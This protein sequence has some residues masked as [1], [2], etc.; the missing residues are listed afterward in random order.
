MDAN[1]LKA[2]LGDEL[3]A[4]VEAKLTAVE[5]LRIIPTNDGSWVPRSR[6]DEEIGKRKPLQDT[7][8]T[9]NADLAEARQKLEASGSLQSQVDQLTR[10]L[11]DRDATITGMRRSGKIREVLSKANLRDISIAEKLLDMSQIKE[12]DKG[13]LTGI[14]EQ[15]K[16]L[17]ESSP[18]LFTD[19]KQSDKGGYFGGNKDHDKTPATGNEQVNQAIR[20]AFGRS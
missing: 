13:N 18:Y 10:D 14:D 20:A 6:L 4:Q 17:K 9:L 1:L 16:A 7:I 2:H 5:D 8:K 3:Y 12:D 15:V 19:E 11:K